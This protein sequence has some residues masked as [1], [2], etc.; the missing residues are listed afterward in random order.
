MSKD[1][2]QIKSEKAFKSKFNILNRILAILLIV[3]LAN[4]LAYL[5]LPIYGK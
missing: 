2:I 5:L 3:Y 1:I 4:T